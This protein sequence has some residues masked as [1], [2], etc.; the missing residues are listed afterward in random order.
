MK[1][2]NIF[3]LLFM[4]VFI[5]TAGVCCVYT[6]VV[7]KNNEYLRNTGPGTGQIRVYEEEMQ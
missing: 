2:R 7:A 4:S 5:K 3:I 6:G 1:S